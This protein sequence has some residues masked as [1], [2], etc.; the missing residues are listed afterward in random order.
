MK[1]QPIPTRPADPFPAI[2][3]HWDNDPTAQ[4]RVLR[5]EVA[6]QLD[7]PSAQTSVFMAAA[8]SALERLPA[9]FFPTERAMALIDI[10]RFYYLGVQSELATEAAQEAV[11]AA[12]VGG[13]R[14]L[15]SRARARHAISLRETYDFFSSIG[16][17][18]RALEIAREEGDSEWEAKVL[19][20]L[21]NSYSDAGLQLEALSIF[22]QI[23]SFFEKNGDRVSAWMALDNAALA[24]LRLGDIQRGTALAE[25]AKAV[26]PGEART[27]NEK[28]WVVQGAL[29][30][31]QLLL[32]AER[33]E[34]AV[35]CAH[36]AHAVSASSGLAQAE[37][38][39]A[40]AEAITTFSAGSAGIDAI[41]RVIARARAESPSQYWSALDAAIRILERAGQFDRALALQRDLIA[42]NKEQKFEAVRR[43]MGR[44]SPEEA[45]GAAKLVQLGTAVDRKVTDLVNTA[46]TQALRAGHDHARIFRVS[47][48]AELFTASV[49]SSP[50]RLQSIA[51]AAKLIDIGMMVIPDDLLNKP[52]RLSDSERRIVEEH[53]KFGA[54]VLVRARLAMLEPC[55]PVV[56]FHHERWDGTG[57]WALKDNGIPVDARVVALCDSFDAL[58][59]ER[60]WRSAFSVPTALRMIGENAGSQFDPSLSERFIA[61]VQNEFW[62]VDDFEAHLAAEASENGYVK[63]RDR[64]QRLIRTA[65]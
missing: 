17:L 36:S 43:A 49:G 29:T 41:D 60:P 47:R 23:A 58:T 54:E 7:F 4:L 52:R 50:A 34:E 31:C 11:R 24:A 62:K 37:T 16:E 30:K 44:P 46:I 48:L 35:A 39:A 6:R 21:G 53:A 25:K 3:G 2:P 1:G 45:D 26:W 40:I 57:A 33:V 51:L 38:L 59:H 15:E 28:L 32:E 10:S 20:S 19:N 61:W 42:L 14:V 18:T 64:I 22:E 56:K 13:H 27:A 55:I 12:V 9:D 8:R 5:E 65:P 63:M